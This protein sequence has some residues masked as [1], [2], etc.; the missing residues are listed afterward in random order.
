M[1]TFELT[2][3]KI[4]CVKKNDWFNKDKVY[5]VCI[6][7]AS[8]SNANTEPRIAFTG[9]SPVSKKIKKGE[10]IELDLG[11]K[12][13]FTIG[14][15]EVYNVSFGLYEYDKGD[16]YDAYSKEIKEIIKSGKIEWLEIIKKEWD[17][18]KQKFPNISIDDLIMVLP[19]FG[20]EIFKELRKDDLLGKRDVSYEYDEDTYRFNPEFDLKEANHHYKIQLNFNLAN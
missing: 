17:Q 11:K 8:N 15:D 7:I 2:V 16:V 18:V 14:S 5:F 1:K 3:P 13:D 6:I 12:W 20:L 9:I 19:H 10:M 4:H